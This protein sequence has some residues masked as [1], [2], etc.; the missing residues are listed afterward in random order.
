MEVKLLRKNSE[1]ET[2]EEFL[3]RENFKL[4]EMLE[5]EQV[6]R[7]HLESQISLMFV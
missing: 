4:S 1:E 7:C 3:R 5:R 6:Q 2:I